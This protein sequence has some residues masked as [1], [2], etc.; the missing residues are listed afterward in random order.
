MVSYIFMCSLTVKKR[1]GNKEKIAMDMLR[2]NKIGND[3]R[4]YE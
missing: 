3:V 1:A 4:E 2:F